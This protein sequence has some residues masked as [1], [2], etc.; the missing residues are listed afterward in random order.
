MYMYICTVSY[1]KHWVCQ[2]CHL[3]SNLLPHYLVIF[4][5]STVLSCNIFLSFSNIIMIFCANMV[6][7]T[8]CLAQHW[9]A[10]RQHIQWPAVIKTR[11]MHTSWWQTQINLQRSVIENIHVRE[12]FTINKK[13]MHHSAIEWLLWFKFHS[14]MS[15]HIWGVVVYLIM[16]FISDCKSGSKVHPHLPKLSQKEWFYDSERIC[17]GS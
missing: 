4:E 12:M 9:T 10:C 7:P 11:S 16:Q 8:K 14:V 17:E 3:A 15:H 6:T 5:C 1:K 2:L 13:I